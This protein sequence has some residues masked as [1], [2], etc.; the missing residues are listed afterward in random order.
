MMA[1]AIRFL[2]LRASGGGCSPACRRV[3][4]AGRLVAGGRRGGAALE[5]MLVLP[6]ILLVLVGMLGLSNFLTTRYYLTAGAIHAARTCTMKQARTL[7]CVQEDIQRFVP[8]LTLARCSALLAT[9]T[10]TP[11]PGTNVQMFDVDLRCT[12]SVDIGGAFLAG[13]GINLLTIQAQGS[14]PYTM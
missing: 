6:T 9:T 13:E 5:F 7:A 8:A 3:R 11:L 1:Q 14:M 2:F 4:R 12:Y 10:N